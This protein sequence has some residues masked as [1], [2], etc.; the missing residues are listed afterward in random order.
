MYFLGLIGIWGSFSMN[1]VAQ[2]YLMYE[3][4][5][6]TAML[7][8]ITLASTA[9]IL[10]LSLFGGAVADRFPKKLLIMV[11][12]AGFIVIFLGYAV[13]DITGYLSQAHPESWWVLLT[14][15]LLMGV[16]IALSMPARG[17]I[18]PEIVDRER[19]MNAVS[20]N[21]MGMSF[22]QMTIP[23]IAGYIIADF[24]YGAIFFIM[25]G[26]NATA[27]FFN[28]L[29]PR[30]PTRPVVN[31]NVMID[32]KEGFKYVLT[33]RTILLVLILFISS[34]LLV[35]P[36]QMLMPVFAKDILNVG[37]EG[38]G[39]L[40]SLMGLGSIVVSF[41]LASFPSR[42]RGLTL[43]ISNICMGAA[44]VSFAFSTLWP[45]SMIMMVLIGMGRIGADACGNTLI[46]SYTDPAILGRVNSIVMLSFGLGGSGSLIV[47][48]LAEAI[49]APWALGLFAIILI[50]S[51]LIAIVFLPSVRKLN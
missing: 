43:L 21:V 45:L 49:G 10:T 40:M 15:G 39:T 9:P 44:M 27:I 46:Q 1:Q 47:G 23:V 51:S 34:V 35:N 42:R 41:L 25:A 18:I 4:T 3:I 7:G 6:S 2:T 38:Q 13:A 33:N 14:G 30:I 31:K 8:V 29:L 22:F 50:I 48:V 11:S 5:G 19:L 17:A 20:L 16:I 37:V 32:I 36:L 24:G 12:H 28:S 26:I